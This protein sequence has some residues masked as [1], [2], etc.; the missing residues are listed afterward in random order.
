MAGKC[1]VWV[2][3]VSLCENNF[4][5]KVNWLIYINFQLDV[6][7]ISQAIPHSAGSILELNPTPQLYVISWTN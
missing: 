3:V 5:I 7:D 2:E 1:Y 6:R 4:S